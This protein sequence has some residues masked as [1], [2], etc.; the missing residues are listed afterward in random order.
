LPGQVR[1][2]QYVGAATIIMACALVLGRLI[3]MVARHKIPSQTPLPA[4]Q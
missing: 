1:L 2:V 4:A 3:Y